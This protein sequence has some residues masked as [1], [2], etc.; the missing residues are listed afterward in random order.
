[1]STQNGFRE[2]GQ[3]SPNEPNACKL[4]K[5]PPITLSVPRSRLTGSA[6]RLNFLRPGDLAHHTRIM[7]T[8]LIFVGLAIS[9]LLSGCAHDTKSNTASKPVAVATM[10][11]T[12]TNTGTAPSN[13][14][15]EDGTKTSS[16][17]ILTINGTN[18]S[19]ASVT[20]Q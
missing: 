4:L 20:N 17:T 14:L 12:F 1:M 3:A 15:W 2:P 7:K 18:A 6:A 10:V 19:G 11:I 13:Y 16:L 9:C 8:L 5:P